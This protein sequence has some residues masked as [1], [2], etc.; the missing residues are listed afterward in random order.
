MR[1]CARGCCWSPFG[2][3]L[4]RACSCHFG[5][6][7]P[8]LKGGAEATYRDPTANEAIGNVMKEGRPR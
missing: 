8:T 4:A 1:P 7:R 6:Q 5:E 3:A 2:C